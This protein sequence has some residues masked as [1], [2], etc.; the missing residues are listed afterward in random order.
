MCN[1]QYSWLNCLPSEGDRCD[2][3]CGVCLGHVVS[4]GLQ[5]VLNE[6]KTYHT[7]AVLAVAEDPDWDG[8]YTCGGTCARVTVAFHIGQL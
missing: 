5:E 8:L 3:C 6:A 2:D 7:L 1:S 4:R